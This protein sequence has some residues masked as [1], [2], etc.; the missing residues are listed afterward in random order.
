MRAAA[1]LTVSFLIHHI[2]RSAGQ[3]GT[4]GRDSEGETETEAGRATET[5]TQ[6][7]D[8]SSLKC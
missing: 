2:R 5:E 8:K 6:I 7:N 4:T 3:H 1:E